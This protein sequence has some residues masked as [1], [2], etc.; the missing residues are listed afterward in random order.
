MAFHPRVV[1]LAADRQSKMDGWGSW[2]AKCGISLVF[3][4]E[5]AIPIIPFKQ[6]GRKTS[7]NCIVLCPD[8]FSKIKE[9]GT[10]KIPFSTIPYYRNPPPNWSEQC[11]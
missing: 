3:K 6:G 2:C 11:K 1:L 9:P 4:R 10:E 7:D 5:Q 8:C